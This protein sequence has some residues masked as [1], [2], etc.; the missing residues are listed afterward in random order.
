M[1]VYVSSCTIY[2]FTALMPANVE[3]VALIRCVFL[4]LLAKMDDRFL[5][6][7]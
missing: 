1:S 6:Q 4:C 5:K 3:I 7:H 2:N